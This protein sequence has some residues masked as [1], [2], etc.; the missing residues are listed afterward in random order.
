VP[1]PRTPGT[2]GGAGMTERILI[3]EDDPAIADSVGR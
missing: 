3:A 2:G 1:S